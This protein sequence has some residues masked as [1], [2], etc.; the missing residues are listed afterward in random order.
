MY[1]FIT[2]FLAICFSSLTYAKPVV[3]IYAASSMTEAVTQVTKHFEDSNIEVKAVFGSSSSLARQIEHKAPA[4]IYISAN[5]LWMDYVEQA[6]SPKQKG[7][8]FAS[9]GLVLTIPNSS[10]AKPIALS[11]A[12]DWAGLLGKQRLAIGEPNTVPVGIYAKETLE[13]L[14]VWDQI[15]EQLAPMKNT[16][17]TLA[18]VERGEVPAGIV[19][20]TDAIQSSKVKVLQVI[21]SQFHEPINYPIIQLSD[22]PEVTKVYNYFLGEEM[23]SKLKELGFTTIN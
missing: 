13:K 23:K 17:A 11:N 18:M 9:N 12:S 7:F 14:K 8:N 21:P 16:R 2:L 10:H 5:T 3:Y 1:R 4:D 20:H 19:Y 15:K 22:K 6:L